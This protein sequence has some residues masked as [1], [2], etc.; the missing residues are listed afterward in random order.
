MALGR[1]KNTDTKDAKEPRRKVT[2]KEFKEALHIFSYIK[3]YRFHFIAGLILLALS[4]LVFMIFLP[5]MGEILNVVT[6]KSKWG[7]SIEEL[8]FFLAIVLVVQGVVSYYRMQTFAV[9]SEK[10]MTDLRKDLYKKL[11]TLD[12][13]FFEKTRVGELTSRITNDVTQLQNVFSVTIAEFLRQ[14]I[15]LIVG[16]L[17]L[18]IV[19]FKLSLIMLA[20]FPPIV[21]AAIFLGRYIRKMSKQR[22]DALAETNI[23]VEETMQSVNAVKAYTN[24]AFEYNRFS[25]ANDT[26]VDI[27]MKF[28]KVRGI[29]AIFIVT[30]LF[31]VITFVVFMGAKMVQSGTLEVGTL[32]TFIFVTMVIGGSIAGLASFYPEIIAAIGATERIREILN[33]PSEVTIQGASTPI[34]R[35]NGNLSLDKVHFSYPTRLDVEVMKGISLDIKAGQKIALVGSSGSGKSTIVQLLLR[36][37][38]ITSGSIKVDGKDITEYD[39]TAYRQNIALVPQEVL[40]FGGS[41]RENIAYGKPNATDEEIIAAAQ[42][43]NAWDFIKDF[44][45]SLDTLVGERGIKLSGGQR[46]RIAIARA[47]LKDPAILL[48]DEATSALDSESEKVVQDALNKLMEGRTSIVVAHRLSTIRDADVIC[49]IDKGEIVEKGTHDELSN[50]QGGIYRQLAALQFDLA[51]I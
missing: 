20:T 35:F 31:G 42:K 23:I 16:V 24:E 11:I 4:S 50:L 43:A 18:A 22:Q 45:E 32:T 6:N 14:V 48:L 9:V 1:P 8:I 13:S 15:L 10:G 25:R 37:Y 34:E 5:A 12:V 19:T 33:T 3:P 40:L 47:I 29:M 38:P 49:V 44:P 26:L 7:Y 21:I 51:E 46:Q 2:G 28:A 41:I 36:F 27:S 30:A 39:I 17:Y